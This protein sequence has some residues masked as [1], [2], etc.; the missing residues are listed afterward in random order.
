MNKVDLAGT[1]GFGRFD[2]QGRAPYKTWTAFLLTVA[3]TPR[4]LT[5]PGK[6]RQGDK[7][8]VSQAT[9]TVRE[10]TRACPELRCLLHGDFG[11]H[12]VLSDGEPD[13]RRD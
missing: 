7:S 3:D 10:L 13:N 4:Y 8:V 12:N 11:S 5:G 1:Q 2:A 6:L 9:S